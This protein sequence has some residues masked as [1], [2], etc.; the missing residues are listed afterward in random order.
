MRDCRQASVGHGPG[1]P[2]PLGGRP[3]LRGEPPSLSRASTTSTPGTAS[4]V[5]VAASASSLPRS[6]LRC[7]TYALLGG[8]PAL[9]KAAAKRS[10]PAAIEEAAEV[11]LEDRRSIPARLPTYRSTL[12][13]K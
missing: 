13:G 7:G 2:L 6:P 11:R 9:A 1:L 8:V 3:P 10:G 12:Y 5:A 4:F